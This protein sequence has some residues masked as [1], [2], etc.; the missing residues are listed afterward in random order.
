MKTYTVQRQ[1]LGDKMYMPGDTRKAKPSDVAHLV[2]SGV[3]V[4][5][6]SV[7]SEKP[8]SNKAEPPLR[9]KAR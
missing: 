5:G 7:K 4:D 3:L 1:H 8:V 2:K 6:E 9:N